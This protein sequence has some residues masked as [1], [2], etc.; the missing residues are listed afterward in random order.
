MVT[1]TTF[2][3]TSRYCSSHLY[4]KSGLPLFGHAQNTIALTSSTAIKKK[5]K[6]MKP[7]D[8]QAKNLKWPP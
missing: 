6:K 1:L 5:Q 7:G 3:R 4:A 2:D 8:F